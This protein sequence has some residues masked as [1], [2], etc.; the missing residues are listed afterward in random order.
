M[1]HLRKATIDDARILFEWRNDPVNRRVSHNQDLISFDTHLA[2]LE[3]ALNNKNRNIFIAL[4]QFQKE[5]G[6]GRADFDGENYKLSWLIAAESMGKGH[7]LNLVT[8]LS[9]MFNPSLA[10]I[11]KDNFAS[12]KIAEKIGFKK[13]HELDGVCFYSFLKIEISEAAP[14]DFENIRSLINLVYPE[15]PWSIEY[16][17][18]QYLS[19]PAGIARIWVAKA[20]GD[21]VSSYAAIPHQFCF[22][23][24][25]TTAWMIQDVLTHPDYRGRGLLHKLAK[26]CAS[27]LISKNYPLNYTFPNQFSHKSFLRSGWDIGF[28]IPLRQLDIDE[29]LNLLIK[30]E[31]INEFVEISPSSILLDQLWTE[32]AQKFKYSVARNRDYLDWRYGQRPNSKYFFYG[33]KKSDKLVALVIL[34]YYDKA[35]GDRIAHICDLIVDPKN[36]EILNLLLKKSIKFAQDQNA[37]KL[38]AWLPLKHFHEKYYNKFNFTLDENL[39]RW[40]IVSNSDSKNK[41]D[42]TDSVNWNLTMGDSDVY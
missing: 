2:W 13:D 4:D 27:Q 25:S 12:I 9:K 3:S 40:L 15:S 24:K 29:S 18:W 20:G 30:D 34:K 39:E 7:G 37:S 10:E 1:I 33:L 6:M 31:F 23:G 5:V 28:R 16:F 26:K 32:A 22:E 19:N 14:N 38:T 41:S 21:I 36:E 42:V 8:E 35:S 11:R 17:N